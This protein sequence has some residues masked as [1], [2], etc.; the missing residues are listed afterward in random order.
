M[1]EAKLF[2][3]ADRTGGELYLKMADGAQTAEFRSEIVRTNWLANKGITVPTFVRV[4]DDG[5]FVA[6][7]MTAV[8]GRHPQHLTKPTSQ[9]AFYLANGLSRLHALLPA[10]C[11]FDET[12]EVRL[13]RAR[14]MISRGLIDPGSFADRNRGLTAEALYDRVLL[15]APKEEDIVV[16]HGDATFDNLLID[17]T[18]AVGFVDCGHAGRGDRYVDLSTIVTDLRSWFG[19]DAVRSFASAYGE[20]PLVGRRLEFFSD[21]YELF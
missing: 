21:L 13:N 17:E 11:P 9:L 3:L 2:H 15:S 10:E 18:G 6:G 16:V 19:S 12:V 8:R 4:F 14:A 1:S 7:L 5:S 20:V